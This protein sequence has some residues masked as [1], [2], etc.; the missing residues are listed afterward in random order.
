MLED[1][2]RKTT[3]MLS[4]KLSILMIYYSEYLF[5]VSVLLDKI[6]FLMAKYHIPFLYLRFPILKM[7]EL[8]IILVSKNIFTSG[9]NNFTSS[10]INLT[11]S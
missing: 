10:K 4:W 6:C 8:R 9:K 3:K 2:S 7:K 11:S 1:L 5:V